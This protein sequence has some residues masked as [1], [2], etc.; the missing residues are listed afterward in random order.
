MPTINKAFSQFNY[1]CSLSVTIFLSLALLN[2]SAITKNKQ[3]KKKPYSFPAIGSEIE[4]PLETSWN[5]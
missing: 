5:R 4:V 2:R 3:K 1:P